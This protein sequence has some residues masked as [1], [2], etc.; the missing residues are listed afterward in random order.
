MKTR[1]LTAALLMSASVLSAAIAAPPTPPAPTPRYVYF[2]LY[3]NL[4]ARLSP[5]PELLEV[6]LDL[7]LKQ[8]PLREAL[9]RLFASAKQ[10]YVV[11]GNVAVERRITLQGKG[12]LLSEALDQ[13]VRQA[14]GGWM[15]QMRNHRPIIRIGGDL[16]FMTIHLPAT[17]EFLKE[18]APLR[19]HPS[20]PEPTA[21]EIRQMTLGGVT[22]SGRAS[23]L[24]G[25]RGI[26]SL[27]VP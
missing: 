17:P 2:T 24:L 7:D 20:S 6:R 4:I 5:R 26:P 23:N 3:S 18:V 16:S 9:Q 8:V 11:E 15:Q 21:Q 14:G 22:A 27:T 13:L 12:M 1:K 25:R 10:E 19:P